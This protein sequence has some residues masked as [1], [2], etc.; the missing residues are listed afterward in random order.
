M[1]GQMCVR[2]W[3]NIS[4]CIRSYSRLHLH[5]SDDSAAMQNERMGKKGQWHTRSEKERAGVRNRD[6]VCVCV[7]VCVE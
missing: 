1:F 2:Q 4:C 3:N 7:R 6:G 5:E